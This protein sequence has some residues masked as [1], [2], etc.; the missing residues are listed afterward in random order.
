MAWRIPPRANRSYISRS[1]I[2]PFAAFDLCRL[3]THTVHSRQGSG[4]SQGEGHLGQTHDGRGRPWLTGV[5][6]NPLI[7]SQ[8]WQCG[9][10]RLPQARRSRLSLTWRD[11]CATFPFLMATSPG[12]LFVVLILLAPCLQISSHLRLDFLFADCSLMAV[13]TYD[14]LG[15]F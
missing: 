13:M 15:C 2:L 8:R 1:A 10:S 3:R 14:H 6:H 7:A 9:R 5:G 4:L 11:D 12:G